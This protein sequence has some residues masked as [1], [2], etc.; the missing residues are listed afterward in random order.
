MSSSR[1]RLHSAGRLCPDETNARRPTTSATGAQAI[2]ASPRRASSPFP[3]AGGKKSVADTADQQIKEAK[4][5]FMALDAPM[6]TSDSLSGGEGSQQEGGGGSKAK[7]SRFF[8]KKPLNALER[9]KSEKQRKARQLRRLRKWLMPK[10]AIV[11]LHE[12]QGPGMT[13]FTIN[14]NGQET[15][16][17]LVINNVRYEA[18][19]PNKNL[20]KAQASEKALRDL[21]FA[22][23]ARVKQQRS[24]GATKSTIASNTDDNV[25][26][27][28]GNSNGDGNDGTAA[29][30]ETEPMD[31]IESEDLPM[32][33]LA[34]FALHKLFT[35]WEA[36]GFEV[37]F[38][39]PSRTKVVTAASGQTAPAANAQP[40]QGGGIMPKVTK[41][42]ADLPSDA[43]KRHP[44]AL[45]AYMRPQIA[46]EDLGSNND[47]TNREFIAGLRSDGQYFIGKGRSKKLARK[48]AAIDACKILFG[49]EFDDSVLQG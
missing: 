8:I 45:F 27:A 30:G 35:Q 48:A 7:D 2:A 34:A 46:Y 37:P 15:K 11:A 25:D 31:C 29:A 32:E 26:G 22:Q 28:N 33:H 42:V 39:K 20:A 13:E 6:N 4:H 40:E 5:N 19:A 43:S 47:Q 36:E 49:V 23:M 10:N 17:E 38:I 12:L 21:V 24:A 1:R 16:A 18:T 44:T 3:F 14:T 41:T 9:K